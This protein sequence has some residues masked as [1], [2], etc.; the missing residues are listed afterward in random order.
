MANPYKAVSVVFI[1]PNQQADAPPGGFQG[2]LRSLLEQR[3]DVRNQWNLGGR[4]VQYINALDVA[5]HFDYR[6]SADDWGIQAHTFEAD[7]VQPMGDGWTVTPRVRYYSQEAA[8]FYTPWLISR[9]AYNDNARVNT[10]GYDPK[11]L[12]ANF[13]SDQRLSG[14][15]ALSGGVTVT[16]R[17]AKGLSLETGF[18]YYTHQGSFKIGG[19]GEGAYAD[20]DYW[21]ANAALKV[22]LAAL[23]QGGGSA[24]SHE[25]KHHHHGVHAPAGVMFD[26]ML[27]KAGD[28]MVGYRYMYNNQNDTMLNG[29]DAVSDRAIVNGGCGS[30]PCFVSPA[31]MAMHMHMLDIMF[32]P[33]DW[34]TLMLMPQFMDMGMT[35]N[36]LD[37]APPDS[38]ANNNVGNPANPF[39]GRLNIGEHITHHVQN[40]HETGGIG[41]L[42]HVCLVQAVRQR[43]PSCPCDRRA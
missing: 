8:D 26:H 27:P 18:E 1:D 31:S 28:L 13:S 16:K 10:L 39:S 34:L 11:K 6:F 30:N 25:H 43:Y 24:N 7:W 14:F 42:G 35:M 29:T 41:D 3:P 19:G 36:R 33:T 40:G 38:V 4:Y 9:E 22:D 12:P 15:G 17:F 32:A 2:V 23:S 21:V 37:G 5:L 20:F